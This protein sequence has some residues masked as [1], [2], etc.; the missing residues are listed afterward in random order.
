MILPDRDV[1]LGLSGEE[2]RI[3]ARERRTAAGV[4]IEVEKAMAA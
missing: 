3:V 2:D 4:T 1:P